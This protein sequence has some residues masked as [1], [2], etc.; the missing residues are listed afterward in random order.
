MGTTPSPAPTAELTARARLGHRG[1]Q[2]LFRSLL[3]ALAHP[4][5]PTRLP[6]DVAPGLPPALVTVLALAD[7]DVP[8]A[9]IGD[10]RPSARHD[11]SA[12]GW[13]DVVRTATGAA[14]APLALAEMIVALR[15]PTPAEVLALERG[16]PDAP[17]RGARLFVACSTLRPGRAGG[18]GVRVGIVGPGVPGTRS[19][20]VVGVDAPA[21][22]AVADANRH[23]PA[24]IDT[25]LVASDGHVVGI[26]RSSRLSIEAVG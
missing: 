15:P 10:D 1:S 21:L 6:D 2:L 18:P 14:A 4:G 24:G 12:G 16:A 9:I 19:F 13:A 23:Y 20:A 11:E 26:P 8:V 3:D 17:E 22:V 5:L 7:V 25:W